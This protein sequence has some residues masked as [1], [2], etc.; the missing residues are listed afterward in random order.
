VRFFIRPG[1]LG[2]WAEN[3]DFAQQEPSGCGS[4]CSIGPS[5][6]SH[7]RPMGQNKCRPRKEARSAHAGPPG[8]PLVVRLSGGTDRATGT[9]AFAEAIK[10]P[11]SRD[12]QGAVRRAAA[13]PRQWRWWPM[14]RQPFPDALHR[15]A[16]PPPIP[17]VLERR[18]GAFGDPHSHS[19]SGA[20]CETPVTIEIQVF[21]GD[22][23]CNVRSSR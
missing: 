18:K 23:Y 12:D 20:I 22:R 3:E 10:N 19:L 17:R 13:G 9:D 21:V 5:T 14:G 7:P 2:F 6:T 1:Y 8:V 11:I 16:P 15:G 4:W